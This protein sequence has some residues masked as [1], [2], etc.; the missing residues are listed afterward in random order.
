[1]N[2]SAPFSVMWYPSVVIVS[3]FGVESKSV[4]VFRVLTSYSA[5]D[6]LR[7]VCVVH[8]CLHSVSYALLFC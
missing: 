5:V 1:M 8:V 6:C 3:G 7:E 4:C 2:V